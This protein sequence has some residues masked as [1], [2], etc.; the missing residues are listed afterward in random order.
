MPDI[1]TLIDDVIGREGGYSDHPAD[2]G[3]AT[4]FGVTVNA[5]MRANNMDNPNVLSIGQQL[6]IPAPA[7]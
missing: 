6:V 2:R 3:G 5:I 1:D 7:E 4:R